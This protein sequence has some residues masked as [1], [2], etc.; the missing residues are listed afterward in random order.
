MTSILGLLAG[1]D[2]DWY[3]N[4][5]HLNYNILLYDDENGDI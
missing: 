1:C 4:R 5:E 2:E 3:H